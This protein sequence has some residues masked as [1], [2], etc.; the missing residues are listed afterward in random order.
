MIA[1]LLSS[2]RIESEVFFVSIIP[3]LVI[4]YSPTDQIAVAAFR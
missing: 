3:C 1:L 2:L 4:F